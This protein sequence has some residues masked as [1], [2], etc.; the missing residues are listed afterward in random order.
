[1]ADQAE[2]FPLFPLGIVL[3]PEEV[4]PLHIFE[5]R[6]KTMIGECIEEG[7]EFGIVWLAPDGLREIGC[8]AEI[9][10]LLER[11]EDGRMNILVRGTRPFRVLERI[12]DMPYPAGDVEILEDES[13]TEP[14]RDE[15]AAEAR[16]RYADL[17]ERLT[18][19]RPD[20]TGLE[21]LGAYGM[22]STI[23][24]APELKQELLEARSESERLRMVGELFVST[25]RRLEFVERTSEQAQSNGHI[26]PSSLGP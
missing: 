16:E 1:M 11:M 10:Q 3:L 12:E 21:Q 8:T 9:A 24:F 25:M 4:V 7:R 14:E 26:K 6:Y 22:A 15:L 20:E 18:D 23:D 19:S 2:R 5:E 17:V 13:S